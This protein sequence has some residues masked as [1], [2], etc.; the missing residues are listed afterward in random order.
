MP[1]MRQLLEG[2]KEELRTWLTEKLQVSKVRLTFKKKDDTIREMTCTLSS[3]LVPQYEKN[4]ERTKAHNPD[5][6]SVFDVEVNE[7]RSMRIDS[8]QTID[9]IERIW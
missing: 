2:N 6:L 8:I 9:S 1:D 3:T 7:W 5:V 4:T